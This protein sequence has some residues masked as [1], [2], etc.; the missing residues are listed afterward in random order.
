MWKI[1]IKIFFALYRY[2]DF[3]VG[4]FYFASPCRLQLYYLL[5]IVVVE[6]CQSHVIHSLCNICCKLTTQLLREL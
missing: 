4:I 5:V 1:C 3:R 6:G 2:R